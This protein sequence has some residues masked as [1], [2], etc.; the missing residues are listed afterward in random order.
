MSNSIKQRC[1]CGS[2]KSFR[3][4]CGKASS[5]KKLELE[6]A[7]KR[8]SDFG[9]HAEAAEALEKRARL[10]PENPMIWNDL[11][12]QRVAAGQVS[13]ALIAFQRALEAFPEYPMALYNLG[14]LS[15]DRCMELQVRG[16]HRGMIKSMDWRQ[17]PR[18]I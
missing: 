12:V 16:Q 14:K 10:S 15:F 2:G 5:E 11:G 7:A 9:M 18:S 3:Q 17:K 8:F 1:S 6:R 4:C 13:D